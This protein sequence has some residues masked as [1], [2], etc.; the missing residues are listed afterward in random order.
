MENMPVWLQV[1]MQFAP[2][3]H[4]V[5]FSQAV[6]YR[7]AGFE[8]VEPQLLAMFLIGL[9]Y[10]AASLLRFRRAIARFR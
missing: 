6:L 10:F 8:I 7:G 2:S 9:V 3:P 5:A 4:F 1:V